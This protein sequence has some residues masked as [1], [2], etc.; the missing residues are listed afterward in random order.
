VCVSSVAGIKLVFTLVSANPLSHIVQHFISYP[1]AQG[2]L[3]N[4][5]GFCTT[6]KAK[7]SKFEGTWAQDATKDE[8]VE[9]YKGWDDQVQELIQVRAF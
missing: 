1:I 5:I 7:P 8:V 3:I 9:Q 6:P 2:R 4:L